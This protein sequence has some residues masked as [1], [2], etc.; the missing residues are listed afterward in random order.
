MAIENV[1]YIYAHKRL[2]SRALRP[3]INQLSMRLEKKQ[4]IE[5]K[6]S[7]K[8]FKK[9]LSKPKGHIWSLKICSN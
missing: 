2:Y 8:T 9:T 5:A 3:V 4:Q 7:F 1:Q 6:N